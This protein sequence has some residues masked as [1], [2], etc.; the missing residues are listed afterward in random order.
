MLEHMFSVLSETH[1]FIISGKP[2]GLGWL[3]GV[4]VL[5]FYGTLLFVLCRFES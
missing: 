5:L 3:L 4:G 2:A 1:G